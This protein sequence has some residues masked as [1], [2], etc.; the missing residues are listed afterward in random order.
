MKR[1]T[2]NELIE[3]IKA[4][5]YT[6]NVPRAVLAL[7]LDVVPEEDRPTST[8]ELERTHGFH[9][10]PDHLKDPFVRPMRVYDVP[11]G[12]ATSDR[13]MVRAYESA[14]MSPPADIVE[15]CARRFDGRH[16]VVM[17]VPWEQCTSS[18]RN[19]RRAVARSVLDVAAA[20]LLGPVTEEERDALFDSRD[21]AEMTSRERTNAVSDMLRARRAKL[22]G[23]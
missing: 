17:E 21:W 10:L 12:E 14:G 15:R 5:K 8:E 2:R 11:D 13:M 22:G 9:P 3:S 19:D 4:E 1:E 18:M 6:G 20:E 23:K 7:L 16:G